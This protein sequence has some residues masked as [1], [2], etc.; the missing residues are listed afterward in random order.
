[1]VP[2]PCRSNVPLSRADVVLSVVPSV[3]KPVAHGAETIRHEVHI[4]AR[5]PIDLNPTP[6]PRQSAPRK[7]LFSIWQS[8]STSRFESNSLVGVRVST[9]FD[10]RWMVLIYTCICASDRRAQGI[11]SADESGHG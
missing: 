11:R 5:R 10:R 6:L 3:V 4:A 2:P 7:K 1:M 9:A 8:S